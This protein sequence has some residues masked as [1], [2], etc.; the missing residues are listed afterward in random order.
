MISTISVVVARPPVTRRWVQHP[1]HPVAGCQ[2]RHFPGSTGTARFAGRS[3]LGR[4][5]VDAVQ[6]IGGQP[7]CEALLPL[8]SGL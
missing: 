2:S 4:V 3:A 7:W 5:R 1:G 6:A 8:A